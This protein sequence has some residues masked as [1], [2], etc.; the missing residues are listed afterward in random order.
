M[1]VYTFL[2]LAHDVLETSEKPLTYHEIWQR[3]LESGLTKKI[4]ST[5]KTPWQSL[6][7]RL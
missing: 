2:D 5:G 6:V 3:G 7:A 4:G 1:A